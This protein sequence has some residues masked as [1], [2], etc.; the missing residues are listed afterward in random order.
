[1][2]N[3]EDTDDQLE[4]TADQEKEVNLFQMALKRLIADEPMVAGLKIWI[5]IA[6]ITSS[7]GLLLGLLNLFWK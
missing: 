2:V 1:M 7:T 5:I 3:Q 6:S 4:L